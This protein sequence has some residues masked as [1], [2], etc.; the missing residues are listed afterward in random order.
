M[1]LWIN[2]TLHVSQDATVF[3]GEKGVHINNGDTDE[4]NERGGSFI[5]ESRDQANGMAIALRLAAKRLE[6]IG[7]G[8]K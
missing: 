8:M 5:P 3:L 7:K 6:D 1:A 2:Q 4:D